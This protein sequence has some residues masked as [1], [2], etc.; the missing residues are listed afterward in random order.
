MKTY[1]RNRAPVYDR[2]YAYPERQQ[3]LRFLE[4]Y[5]AAQMEG[6][7]ETYFKHSDK[8]VTVSNLH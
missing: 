8:I 2:V 7:Q 3:D 4:Q 6:R 5:V 1:Y